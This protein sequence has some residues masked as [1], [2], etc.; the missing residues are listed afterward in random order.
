MGQKVALVYSRDPQSESE[1]LR[2][3]GRAVSTVVHCMLPLLP[4][5]FTS[6][7]CVKQYL[8]WSYSSEVRPERQDSIVAIYD[9]D[10]EYYDELYSTALKGLTSATPVASFD[11]KSN[12][13]ICRLAPLYRGVRRIGVKVLGVRS[14]IRA[15]LRYIKW[16]FIFDH[17]MDYVI[18]K[19]ERH[20]GVKLELTPKQKRH[21]LLFGWPALFR[22][23][24][25]KVIN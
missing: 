23:F 5:R 25:T 7:D 9:K 15:F 22:L 4:E 1:I 20:S 13:F 19:L 18:S 8:L 17:A 12:Q 14:R 21:P 16:L 2:S 3:L 24:R 10:R 11:E 6:E